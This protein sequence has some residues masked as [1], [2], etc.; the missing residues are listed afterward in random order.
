MKKAHPG[1]CTQRLKINLSQLKLN[2]MTNLAKNNGTDKPIQVK[3][4]DIQAKE[5][6][7]K[8]NGNSYFACLVTINFGMS[9][10]KIIK[11]PF[12]YGYGDHYRTRTIEQLQTDGILP[13]LPTYEF[14]NWFIDN[15]I[16]VRYSK[17]ENCKKSELKNI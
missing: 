11:V 5:W 14:R 12:Q 15:G 9:D 10:E 7:D 17:Q 8:I 2:L 1:R 4:I 6:F 16:I 13:N 3:T